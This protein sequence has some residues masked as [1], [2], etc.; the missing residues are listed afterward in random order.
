MSVRA[1]NNAAHRTVDLTADAPPGQPDGVS[2]DR[3]HVVHETRT[4]QMPVPVPVPMPLP[5]PVEEPPPAPEPEPEPTP[6]LTA[7]RDGSQHWYDT[8]TGDGHLEHIESH[9]MGLGADESF[10]I[11][12]Q[13][14]LGESLLEAQREVA[15]LTA[16]LSDLTAALE[17]SRSNYRAL[18]DL[19]DEE[20][21]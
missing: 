17:R 5:P 15:R 11:V 9:I 8:D 2:E 12:R 4:E 18:K 16:S 20:I 19:I 14:T 21:S 3:R 10:A 6:L 7:L 13:I 1:H